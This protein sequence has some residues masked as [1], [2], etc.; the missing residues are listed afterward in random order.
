MDKRIELNHTHNNGEGGWKDAY[1]KTFLE[2]NY[3]GGSLFSC[4]FLT[5]MAEKMHIAFRAVGKS[6]KMG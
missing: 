5:E 2:G 6:G 1:G 3:K 4:I